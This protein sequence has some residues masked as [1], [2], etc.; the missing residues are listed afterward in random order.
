MPRSPDRVIEDNICSQYSSDESYSFDIWPY[1]GT[2]SYMFDAQDF[3]DCHKD[4]VSEQC[5][6]V[7]ICND[8]GR[9]KAQAPSRK[10]TSSKRVIQVA[11]AKP[12]SVN[13]NNVPKHRHKNLFTMHDY[14][15]ESE[16]FLLTK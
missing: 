14:I 2:D 4:N 12:T 7:N 1:Q 8:C 13:S 16:G 6:G 5:T 3:C 9:P 15:S 10:K 11:K